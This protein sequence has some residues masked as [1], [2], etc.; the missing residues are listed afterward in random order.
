[1]KKMILLFGILAL[2]FFGF[3]QAQPVRELEV[4]VGS[5][6][7]VLLTWDLPSGSDSNPMTISWITSE[8]N[9]GGCTQAGFDDIFGHKY[10]SIDLKNHVGWRIDTISFFKTTQ[11]TY[12]ICIWRQ[13]NGESMELIHSQLVHVNDSILNE[14]CAVG[15]DTPIYIEEDASYWFGIRATREEG[16][17]GPIFPIPFDRG[18]AVTGKG[19]LF[20]PDLTHWTSMQIGYNA[21]IKTIVNNDTQYNRQ[22]TS[23]EH[24]TGYRIYRNGEL[25]KEIPYSFVTYFADT[26]FTRE[27]DVEYCVTAVY[28][29]EESEPVCAT[30]TISSVADALAE[31]DITLSPNPT[32]GILHVD[33]A[34]VVEVQVYNALGQLVKTVRD[35]NEINVAGLAE[36]V[37]LV[38][39]TDAEGRNLTAK[40][41]V[42]R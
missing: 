1:M 3:G 17:T 7:N 34:T 24:L 28:G 21:M 5:N 18:P 22:A 35:T 20:M 4:S 38:Q 19:D 27:I 30:A 25:I 29:E 26:E 39:I 16:Q 41:M 31:D 11:W 23:S 8:T 9:D 14:W 32:N 42:K 12:R 33:G 6:D 36:G 15:L 13:L 10:N 37:Y 40:V 2:S